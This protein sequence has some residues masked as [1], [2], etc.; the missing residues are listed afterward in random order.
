MKI[1]QNF[2]VLSM[3]INRFKWEGYYLYAGIYSTFSDI[4]KFSL[5]L[6]L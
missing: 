5:L 2:I 6:I 4:L 3:K 1:Q